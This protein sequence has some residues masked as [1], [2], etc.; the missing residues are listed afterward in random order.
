MT[1]G[2]TT[3]QTLASLIEVDQATSGDA[4]V[5]ARV[6]V[7]VCI[8]TSVCV[9]MCMHV[10]VHTCVCIYMLSLSLTHTHTHITHTHTLSLSLQ[11]MQDAWHGAEAYHFWIL[12]QRQLFNGTS[13]WKSVCVYEKVRVCVRVCVRASDT[14]STVGACVRVR[15]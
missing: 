1:G 3:Q 15:V 8:D 6:C 10:Y 11:E 12:C 13:L 9:C 5:R 7:Y 14:C 2:A 4:K